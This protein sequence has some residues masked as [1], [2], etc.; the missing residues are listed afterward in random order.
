M[1]KQTNHLIKFHDLAE[2]CCIFSERKEENV[3]KNGPVVNSDSCSRSEGEISLI[4]ACTL[5][6]KYPDTE[7]VRIGEAAYLNN[8]ELICNLA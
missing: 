3:L 8:E 4:S 2:G 7:L 1:E 5:H 6:Q